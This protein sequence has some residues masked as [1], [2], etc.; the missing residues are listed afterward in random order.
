MLKIAPQ[1]TCFLFDMDGTLVD[2]EPVGPKVFKDL[3]NDNGVSLTDDEKELFVKI[4]RRDGTDINEDDYLGDLAIKYKISQSVT[5]FIEEF[6]RRYKQTIINA[7]ELPG[8]SNF[9]ASAKNHGKR[10][11]LITSSKRDQAQ[12]VL[13]F[14]KWNRYFD[15]IVAEEDITKF[16]PDPEPFLIAMD[17]L[18][19]TASECIVFEDAKNGA[20]AGHA[21]SAFVIGLRA[22]NEKQQDLGSA[23]QVVESFSDLLF[24]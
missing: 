23:D 17:K 12:A 9:L 3:F 19:A 14:H 15:C 13:E 18:S 5:E 2:T 8:T 1:Y 16:K 10:L 11:A 4:W 21:A 20:I 24:E 7:D 6:Y 22:G